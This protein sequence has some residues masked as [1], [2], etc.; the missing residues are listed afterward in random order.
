MRR[1]PGQSIRSIK[2]H[3]GSVSPELHLHFDPAATVF[4]AVASGLFDTMRLF[5][6]LSRTER[7]KALAIM[8]WLKID[9]LADRVLSELST[10]WQRMVL[11]ARALVKKPKLLILDE[12]C[13]SLDASHRELFL[14]Q[15][16]RLIERQISTVI[17]VT[18]QEEEIPRGITRVLR[19]RPL[20]AW[21][22]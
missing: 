20:R 1:G 7:K 5:S 17:Y 18:H 21:R 6:P 11:L 14:K 3:L 22:D 2:R 12:P 9:P 16:E 4:E 13:Q 10:G 8:R 15:V 19:L